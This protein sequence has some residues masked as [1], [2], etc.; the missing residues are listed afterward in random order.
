MC[1]WDAVIWCVYNVENKL[2]KCKARMAW[3][4]RHEF[5]AWVPDMP[6]T[7][8]LQAFRQLPPDQRAQEILRLFRW[9][10]H[11]HHRQAAELVQLQKCSILQPIRN[12]Q[13]SNLYRKF[14]LLQLFRNFNFWSPLLM[15]SS[16]FINLSTIQ[17]IW[18]LTLQSSSLF[19]WLPPWL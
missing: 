17:K 16:K 1:W 2:P 6:S 13:I 4:S 7:G 9:A 14:Q 19:L 18:V 11:Q 8:Q 10:G 12:F 3:G 15:S 5:Q